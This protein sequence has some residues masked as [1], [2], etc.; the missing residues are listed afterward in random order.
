MV[1][2]GNTLGKIE[3]LSPENGGLLIKKKKKIRIH[4]NYIEREETASAI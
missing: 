3:L 4:Y 1:L 2:E